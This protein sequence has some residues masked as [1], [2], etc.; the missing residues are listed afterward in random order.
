MT[1][2]T[3]FFAVYRLYRR[4]AHSRRYCVRAA[5]NTVFKAS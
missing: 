4:A 5:F 3:D 2:L 1:R